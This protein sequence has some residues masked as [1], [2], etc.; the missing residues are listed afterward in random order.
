MR[1]SPV[2]IS[3]NR[4]Q[5]TKSENHTTSPFL[6]Y[7]K[8]IVS[9]KSADYIGE[10]LKEVDSIIKKDIAPFMRDS[11]DLYLNVAKI[12]M[13][14]QES[15]RAFRKEETELFNLKLDLLQDSQNPLY[16]KV[17]KY[18]EEAERYETNVRN[19]DRLSEMSKSE[20][21]NTPEIKEGVKELKSLIYNP[22][23]D[24]KALKRFKSAYEDSNDDLNSL[25][26][27]ISLKNM[28]PLI[29]KRVHSLNNRFIAAG[30]YM[31]ITPYNDSVKLLTE[32]KALE[33]DSKKT[34]RN[35]F[36]L[37]KRTEKLQENAQRISDSTK[38]YYENKQKMA[39]MASYVKYLESITPSPKE[40][41]KV[42]SDFKNKCKDIAQS[43]RTRF[44]KDYSDNFAPGLSEIDFDSIDE[45]LNKQDKKAQEIQSMIDKIKQ[46]LINK[47]NEDFM[48]SYGMYR[49]D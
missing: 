8:D 24:L 4:K 22:N 37:I 25:L 12:G 16:P 31:S 34:S 14:A 43:S 1:I 29:F 41:E 47:N 19:Y 33:Q 49:E 42:Y 46:E 23:R 44:E 6:S 7:E 48:K 28:N 5:N 2:F 27:N 13:T 39:K 3:A 15:L 30:Y 36:D 11:K 26:Q 10:G 35:I 9:F 45:L 18:L 40:L 17:K 21:Y 32:R 38:L 20:M